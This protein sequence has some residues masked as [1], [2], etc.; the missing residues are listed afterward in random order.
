MESR[1]VAEY[2]L[3]VGSQ[4][5]ALRRARAMRQI[6]FLLLALLSFASPA[7]AVPYWY[8]YD[9]SDFPENEGWRRRYGNE[10]GPR[11]GGAERSIDDGVLVLDSLRHRQIFDFYEIQG[12]DD[13]D[14]GETFV[15]EWRTLISDQRDPFDNGVVIARDALPGHITFKLAA[16]QILIRYTAEDGII[17]PYITPSTKY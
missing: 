9:G 10:D 16:D 17:I 1:T 13:P 2:A 4:Y 14:L 7:V 8:S 3:R 11:E 15:A 6:A 5:P 12:I